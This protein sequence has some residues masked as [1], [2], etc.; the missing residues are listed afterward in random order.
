VGCVWVY[1]EKVEL[2]YWWEHMISWHSSFVSFLRL[3]MVSCSECCGLKNT[4]T[5]V[6]GRSDAFKMA[7]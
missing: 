3:G 2:C 1:M 4:K 5:K 6:S 7:C